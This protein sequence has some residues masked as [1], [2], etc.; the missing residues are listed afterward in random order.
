MLKYSDQ[1]T[2]YLL[3]LTLCAPC[4]MLV[5]VRKRAVCTT[6]VVITALCVCAHVCSKAKNARS[7]TPVILLLYLK[8]FVGRNIICVR[9]VDKDYD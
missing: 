4:F 5:V 6:G 7:T 3:L 8:L 2:Q 9:I 1:R